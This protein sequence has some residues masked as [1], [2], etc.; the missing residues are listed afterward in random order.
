[1]IGRWSRASKIGSTAS[2]PGGRPRR[3]RRPWGLERLE[4]RT[5]LSGSPTVFT[6]TDASD[7]VGD[8]GSLPYAIAQAN[9]NPNSDGSLIQFD[10]TAFGAS[11]PKTIVLAGTLTLSETA[12]PEVIDGPGANA[13]TIS[14]N[15]AVQVFKV[16]ST[17]TTATLSGLTISG[18]SIAHN[19]GGIDNEGTLTLTNCTIAGNSASGGGNGGGIYNN[20]PLTVMGCTLSGNSVTGGYGGGI[21][22]DDTMSLTNSTV[23]G[24]SDTGGSGGGIDN[25]TSLTITDC[26]IID[27]TASTGLAGGG[28]IYNTN[29]LTVTDSTLAGNSAPLGGGLFSDGPATVTDSTLAGNSADA[30]GGLFNDG[31]SLTVVNATVARNSS[32]AAGFAGGLVADGAPPVTLNNTIVDLNT[33]GATNSDISVTGGGSVS[34][35]SGFNLIGTVAAGI[36]INGVNGNQ[37]G[38]ADPGLGPLAS[39]GG[40]TQTIALLTGSPAIDAGSNVLDAGQATDQRGAGLVR[41]FNGT[42]DIGAYEFQPASI[43]SVS[44]GWGTQTAAVQIAADGVRLLPAGRNTDLP[45]LGIDELQITLDEPETLTVADVTIQGLRGIDYGPVTING[46]GMSYTITFAQPIEKADRVT[47]AIAG[48]GFNSFSGRLDVLPGDFND[49]GRV[50]QRDVK[51][52][53]AEINGTGGATPTI[54]GDINGDGVVNSIDLKD[55]RRRIGSRLPRVRTPAAAQADFRTRSRTHFSRRLPRPDVKT[56]EPHAAPDLVS[57]HWQV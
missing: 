28:G 12:G 48:A 27:N 47:V 10:P 13:L 38:V 9:I 46:S 15:H 33:D 57:W 42:V 8:T 52:I 32:S 19:G 49:D 54:F 11:N 55:V 25:E 29:M 16:A 24:N 6:V 26:S 31:S 35:T 36:L 34:P 7:S 30:G 2:R 44:V 37:V 21:A 56:Y 22:N 20:G 41:V 18:G 4:D 17:A 43:V 5:L 3:G 53:R 1:M 23:A 45:W 50:N 14:G 39:N 51:G 40:P